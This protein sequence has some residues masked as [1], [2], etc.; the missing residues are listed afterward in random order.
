MVGVFL[1]VPSINPAGG[2]FLVE[3]DPILQWLRDSGVL[4]LNGL[5]TLV[6]LAWERGATLLSLALAGL[7]VAWPDRAVQRV[8][9]HRPRRHKR[10]SVVRAAPVAQIATALTA[11]A[12]TAASLLSHAPVTLWG[13]ALWAALLAGA[14]ALPRERENILWT[15]KGA[16]VGY[17]AL[18]IGLRLIFDAPVDT[19]GWSELMGVEQGGAALLGSV[20]QSLAPWAVVA[21]WAIYPAG[22]LALLGQRLLV[23]RS[24]LV[25]PMVSARQ[26]IAN[27]RTRGEVD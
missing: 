25:S 4:V 18:A 14:L 11:A 9:G 24:R 12:W 3:L 8:A 21:T 5:L 7:V 17:A 22:A 10:G 15:H 6:Y 23:N 2:L 26:V 27:L 13:V 20:R 16:I 19:A 1:F